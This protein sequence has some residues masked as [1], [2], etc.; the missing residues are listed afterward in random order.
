MSG[1]FRSLFVVLLAAAA[2]DVPTALPKWNTRW[3]LATDSTR[4]AVSE[5][6]PADV[7]VTPDGQAFELDLDPVRF[8]RT[9]GTLCAQCAAQDGQTVAKPAFQS[10]F[11]DRIVRPEDVISASV[12]SGTITVRVTNGF[13][14]DP[15]R[16]GGPT[17]GGLTIRVLDGS[18]VLTADSVRGEQTAFPP[19]TTL[20]HDLSVASV[21]ITGDLT[22]RVFLDSPEG[23]VLTINASQQ[24]AVNADPGQV[25][26]SEAHVRVVNKTASVEE[27]DLDLEDVE[28]TFVE[29]VRGGGFV[30]DIQNPFDVSGTFTLQI[31]GPGTS[32]Q[33]TFT[34]GPGATSPSVEFNEAELK[35]ILGFRRTLRASGTVSARAPSGAVALRPDQV[36]SIKTK[37]DLTIASEP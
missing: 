21:T 37:L 16:P 29:R 22:V 15:I 28:D 20:T 35:E 18:T 19:G 24:V 31:T 8:S 17:Q 3:I 10:Q 6:L 32:I 1:N 4:L 2:C 26:L 23:G 11:E 36:L 14:F 12:T 30:F 27:V 25:R 33:K 7:T 5:L 13:S 34:I 9:L